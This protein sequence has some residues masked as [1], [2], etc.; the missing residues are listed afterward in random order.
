MQDVENSSQEV[1][2]VQSSPCHVWSLKKR[3][4][5]HFFTPKSIQLAAQFI[6]EFCLLVIVKLFI[7]WNTSYRGGMWKGRTRKGN[8]KY[9][10]IRSYAAWTHSRMHSRNH[11]LTHTFPGLW[12]LYILSHKTTKKEWNYAAFRNKSGIPYNL[13]SSCTCDCG[14]YIYVVQLNFQLVHSESSRIHC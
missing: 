2:Q 14:G 12:G 6:D 3:K 7:A 10:H 13:A 1:A 11:S 4:I 5:L 9:A 8:R